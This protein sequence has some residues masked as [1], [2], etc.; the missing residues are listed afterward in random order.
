VRVSESLGV[1]TF[2]LMLCL[3]W[4]CGNK[5]PKC[6]EGASVACA[7]RS[8]GSGA[9]VCSSDGTFGP[10]SCAGGTGGTA[11][12]QHESSVGASEG[13]RP[14][15]AP[16]PQVIVDEELAVDADGWQ[17]RSFTLASAHPIQVSAEGRSHADKGFSVYVMTSGEL[18]HF[19][20]KETF[21]HIPTLEGLKVRSFKKTA[22]LAP[23]S[24]TVVV[25]NSEN[26]LNT[27]VVRLRVVAAP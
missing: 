16:S 4:A 20:N 12:S 19:R 24:W 17:A 21:R 2:T 27:M 23:G 25:F 15:L 5:R 26:I 6:V 13:P 22:T 3:F 1:F 8:G 11:S 14:L 18:D 7:C 9:Q 10:C